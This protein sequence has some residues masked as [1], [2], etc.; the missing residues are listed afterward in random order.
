MKPAQVHQADSGAALLP[1]A[2]P[3]NSAQKEG[4]D[5]PLV[6]ATTP[7]PESQTKIAAAVAMLL[8]VAAAVI[9]PFA[10]V[11][12]SRT[13]KWLH[14]K[15]LVRILADAGLSGGLRPGWSNR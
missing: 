4:Q 12:P 6:I 14:I 11:C 13:R 15:R 7:A 8:I 2:A 1:Q 3:E 10:A 9:A 5:F